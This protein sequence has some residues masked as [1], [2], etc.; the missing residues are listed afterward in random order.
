MSVYH[1]YKPKI[2]QIRSAQVS[3]SVNAAFFL[4]ILFF[5]FYL[6]G[7]AQ[8]PTMDRPEFSPDAQVEDT[9]ELKSHQPLPARSAMLSATLPGLGQAYNGAYWKIP[10][11][12]AGFGALVYAVNFNNTKYQYWR[13]AYV[14]KVDGNPNTIDNY[15]FNSDAALKRQMEYF[16]RNL[17]VTYILGAVLYLLNILDAN[18]QAH[19]MDFD[20]SPDLSMKIQPHIAPVPSLTGPAARGPGLTLTFRF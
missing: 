4:L 3:G 7:K 19:L 12:Y 2:R 9:L 11:I 5:L 15:P 8:Q 17:E 6:P 13:K 10:I 1:A 16:R 18:V 20:I 14:A